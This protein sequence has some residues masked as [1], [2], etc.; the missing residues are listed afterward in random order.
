[1]YELRYSRPVMNKQNALLLRKNFYSYNMK[2]SHQM[3]INIT[4]SHYNSY[5]ILFLHLSFKEKSIVKVLA[6]LSLFKNFKYFGW[7]RWSESEKMLFQ[8]KINANHLQLA[9][10]GRAHSLTVRVKV[11]MGLKCLLHSRLHALILAASRWHSHSYF[12]T[13]EWVWRKN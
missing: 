11:N 7:E 12:Q 6:I 5:K 9:I 3:I 4:D 8:A 13:N 2:D 10:Q 1:M